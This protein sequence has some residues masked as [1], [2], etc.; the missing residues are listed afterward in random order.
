MVMITLN[1]T[2]LLNEE[3]WV[4]IEQKWRKNVEKKDEEEN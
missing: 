3:N 4:E 1:Q 2:K